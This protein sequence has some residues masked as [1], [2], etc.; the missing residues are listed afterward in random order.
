[1]TLSSYLPSA[2]QLTA[3]TIAVLCATVIA[4]YVITKIPAL[5]DLVRRGSVQGPLS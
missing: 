2:R 3:E 5:Q 1:M 4:A